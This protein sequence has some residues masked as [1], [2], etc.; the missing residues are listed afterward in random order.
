MKSA[1]EEI[2]NL[3]LRIAAKGEPMNAEDGNEIAGLAVAFNALPKPVAPAPLPVAR[4]VRG[5]K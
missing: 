2:C 3:A 4:V 5:S 1:L